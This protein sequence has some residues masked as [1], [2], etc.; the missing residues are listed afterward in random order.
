MTPSKTL[1]AAAAVLIGAAAM[2]ALA[3]SSASSA[4]SESVSV[5]IGSLSGSIKNSSESSNKSGGTAAGD[6][7]IVDVAVVAEQP[8]LVR[9][10]LQ[11]VA[12]SGAEGE[13]TLTLPQEVF[14]RTG[15]AAD[16]IVVAADRPYGIEFAQGQPRRPFFLVLA[17]DW[18]RE[19]QTRAVT[20]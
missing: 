9:L 15:L 13:F 2:P 3:G 19:L 12:G 10:Q 20:L 14:A 1:L 11:A 6:Y 4:L 16:G 17:D 5:S 8:A 18:Y 7:R